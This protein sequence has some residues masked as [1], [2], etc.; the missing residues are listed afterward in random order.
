M[1]F[2]SSHYS[3]CLKQTKKYHPLFCYLCNFQNSTGLHLKK[4][5]IYINSCNI[6][7]RYSYHIE[8]VSSIKRNVVGCI[9]SGV[10]KND[11]NEIFAVYYFLRPIKIALNLTVIAT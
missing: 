8:I 11:P 7:T 2:V 5:A 3:F 9:K 6:K 4:Y 10:E 1:H